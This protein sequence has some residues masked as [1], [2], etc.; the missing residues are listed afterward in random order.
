MYDVV[1]TGMHQRLWVKFLSTSFSFQGCSGD[2]RQLAD[3]IMPAVSPGREPVKIREGEEPQ[4]FWA[5][6]GGK[7][8]YGSGRWLEEV[9][10]THPPRLF[11]C[12]NATGHF[13]VEEIYDFAQIVSTL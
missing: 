7:A 4:E 6:L 10:P 5:A 9:I 12:S 2:E 8:E 11:Q 1:T 3:S 13:N